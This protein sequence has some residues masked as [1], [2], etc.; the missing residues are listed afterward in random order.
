MK[1]NTKTIAEYNKQQTPKVKDVCTLLAKIISENL[2]KSE[3]K[4]W[5]G[6]PVWFLEGNPIVAYSVRKGGAVSLMFFSGQ[7]FEEEELA[8]SGKFQAAEVLYTSAEDVRPA[9]LKRWI[10]KSRTIQWDYK[11][12][13][14]NK[15]KLVRLLV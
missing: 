10:K 11:N 6:S 8:A 14:K 1:T 13:I 2:K 15:G 5:H 3:S 12:I 7:S 9:A 4:I